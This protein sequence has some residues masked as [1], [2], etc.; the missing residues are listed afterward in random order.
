M[1]CFPQ[2]AILQGSYLEH[3]RFLGRMLGKVSPSLFLIT[4]CGFHKFN[5]IICVFV[6]IFFIWLFL[7]L[8]WSTFGVVFPKLFI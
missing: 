5:L 1:F 6:S 3:I 2:A 8:F 7:L 4:F